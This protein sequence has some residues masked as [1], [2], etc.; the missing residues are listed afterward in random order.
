M[1]PAAIY[2]RASHELSLQPLEREVLM[3]LLRELAIS[4]VSCHLAWNLKKDFLTLW[5][6]SAG[7]LKVPSRI[8]GWFIQNLPFEL[9]HDEQQILYL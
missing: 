3:R 5:F 4:T 6:I 2:R 9:D 7:N 1:K 8:T